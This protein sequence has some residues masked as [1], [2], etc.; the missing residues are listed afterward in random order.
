MEW[1]GESMEFP[2]HLEALRREGAGAVLAAGGGLDDPV[3]GCPEWSV[4][5][6]AE[7]LGVIHHRV[8]RLI[9]EGGLEPPARVR[10]RIT[11]PAADLRAGWLAEGLDALVS[12]LAAAEPD[13]P[14]WTWAPPHTHRFWAR[15]M[16]LE[17][18]IH[19][20]DLESAHGEPAAIEPALAV[21][22]IDEVFDVFAPAR[23]NRASGLEPWSYGGRGERLHL[24]C[25]DGPGEW[26]LRFG[27]DTVEI[28][29]EHAR[30]DAALRGSAS[31]LLLVLYGRVGSDRVEVLGDPA[32]VRLWTETA[33]I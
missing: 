19:R 29:R 30:G 33:R 2:A 11:A 10:E 5:D 20:W 23:R 15:R 21:D 28:T 27:P 26:L 25:T 22:G 32:V 3:P 24:H 17:T 13:A 12:A 8:A 1:N 16:A 31:D 9:R 18:A 4:A 14:V 6:L 7:H